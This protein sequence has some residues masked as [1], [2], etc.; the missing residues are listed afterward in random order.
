MYLK[1]EFNRAVR[2]TFLVWNLDKMQVP[3]KVTTLLNKN[4][5]CFNI[6]DSPSPI[7]SL[8]PALW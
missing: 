8:V 1:M 4:Y 6:N 5:S 3:L 7:S 2:P